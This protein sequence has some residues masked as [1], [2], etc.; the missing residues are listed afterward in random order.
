MLDEFAS[1]DQ[2][3][4]EPRQAPTLTSAEE[5]WAD[6]ATANRLGVEWLMAGETAPDIHA[7][8]G[9]LIRRPAWHH[10][11]AC[12]GA[13]SGAVLSRAGRIVEGGAFL[14]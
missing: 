6:A 14:L 5:A 10:Y 4:V 11:A 9:Q 13:D 7:I 1:E 3:P 8:L 12:R 2:R